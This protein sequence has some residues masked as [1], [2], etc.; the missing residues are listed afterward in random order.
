M[1]SLKTAEYLNPDYDTYQPVLQP[2]RNLLLAILER[3]VL[4][5]HGIN[6]KGHTDLQTIKITARQWIASTRLFPFSYEWVCEH[7]DVDA[8]KL[9]FQLRKLP[10][11][12]MKSRLPWE[13]FKLFV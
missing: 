12:C 8:T 3:A 4:D 11:G 2:E 13:A 5:A 6:L 9:R 10:K 1:I 7:L